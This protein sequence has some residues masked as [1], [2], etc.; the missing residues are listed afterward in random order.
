[1]IADDDSPPS[2]KLH[3]K[4]TPAAKNTMKGCVYA[5]PQYCLANVNVFVLKGFRGY[6]NHHLTS[7]EN[8]LNTSSLPQRPPL[9][10]P[11]LPSPSPRT[12]LQFKYFLS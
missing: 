8:T 7:K 11:P 12:T 4:E 9:P 6:Q 2:Q 3:I 5:A 1:M 10:P